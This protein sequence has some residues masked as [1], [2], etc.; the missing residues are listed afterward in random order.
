MSH[1]KHAEHMPYEPSPTQAMEGPSFEHSLKGTTQALDE[2]STR[3]TSV[4]RRRSC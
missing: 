3:S 2:H 1:P 4:T